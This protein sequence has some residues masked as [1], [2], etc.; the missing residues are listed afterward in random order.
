MRGRQHGSLIAEREARLGS[1]GPTLARCC[2][3]KRT[4]NLRQV[5]RR[6]TLQLAPNQLAIVEDF[7]RCRVGHVANDRVAEEPEA[8]CKQPLGSCAA[9]AAK[10][11]VE[12]VQA[13]VHLA[14][15]EVLESELDSDDGV[16]REYAATT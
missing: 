7:K 14:D 3:G 6:S 16:C 11:R 8:H 12:A 10:A 4:G 5:W 15:T 13:I 2:L 9:V 1:Q